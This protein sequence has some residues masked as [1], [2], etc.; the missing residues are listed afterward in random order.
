MDRSARNVKIFGPEGDLLE[1]DTVNRYRIPRAMDNPPSESDVTMGG[2]ALFT[3][4]C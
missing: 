3:E 2:G 4:H 1:L